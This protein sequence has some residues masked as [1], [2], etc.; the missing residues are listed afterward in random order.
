MKYLRKFDSVSDMETAIASSEIDIIGLAYNGSTPVLRIKTGGSPGPDYSEPFYID[1][2][3]AVT[4]AATSGLQMSSDKTNWTDATAMTLPTGKTYFR[5]ASDKLNPLIPRWTED[6]NSDYD[7][8]GNINSLMKVNFENDT[9]C[10]K[11]YSSSIY[12]GF[13]QNKNKLKSAGNLILPATILVANC[14]QQMFNGCTSLTTA[15]ALP[16]TTLAQKCY[17]SMFSGCTSLTTAPALPA[18]TLAIDCYNSMFKGCTSLTTAPTLPVTALAASCYMSMFQGCTSLTT[19][20]A[21]PAT[22]LANKCYGSMFYGCTGLTTAPTLPAT[23]L[24]QNCYYGMFA[25]C[26][27]LSYIKCL[28]TD[29]SA[30]DCTKRW[31]NGV[32]STGTFVKAASMSSWPRGDGGIPSG[33]TVEDATN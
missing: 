6:S 22:T 33:W 18:T 5:V 32:A 9:T 26:T 15:P 12:K 8:G 30:T 16:A 7:I 4:L 3:G 13:F 20:P 29:I 14:Y 23:T 11:F 31:V 21:L 28:A 10:Y 17:N 19:A 25:D 2:R 24:A 27:N 1:V